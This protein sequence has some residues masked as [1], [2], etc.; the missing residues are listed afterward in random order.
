VNLFLR[1]RANLV[2]KFKPLGAM[3]DRCAIPTCSLFKLFKEAEV[4]SAMF[5]FG[6]NG[7][8]GQ[9]ME[10]VSINSRSIKFCSEM[11]NLPPI[12]TED[13]SAK[14][15]SAELQL[16]HSRSEVDP[17]TN[18]P[19]SSLSFSSIFNCLLIKT[20]LFCKQV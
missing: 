12:E 8:S 9:E 7:L 15:G 17:K 4:A 2:K 5:R 11:F 14:L 10:A 19:L 13:V 18:T 3:D 16:T 20:S 6:S 1:G